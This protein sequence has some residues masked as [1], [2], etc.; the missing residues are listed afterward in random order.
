M[1]SS[2]SIIFKGIGGQYRVRGG[3]GG[4]DNAEFGEGDGIAQKMSS[5]WGEG[6]KFLTD[7]LYFFL[8]EQS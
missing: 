2:C 1:N 4:N 5:K 8:I 3:G 7:T 6:S